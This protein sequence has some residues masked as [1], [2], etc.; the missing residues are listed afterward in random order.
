[1]KTGVFLTKTLL[2]FNLTSLNKIHP[3]IGAEIG[4]AIISISNENST[5]VFPP[6]QGLTITI[7]IQAILKQLLLVK[8]K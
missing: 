8:Q 2:S 3:Y 7:Q 4:A 5:Q 1:M 6:D